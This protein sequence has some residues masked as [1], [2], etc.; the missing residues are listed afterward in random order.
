M[1]KFMSW[2]TDSFSPKINKIAKNPWIASIQDAILA[3]MPMIFIGSFA[4][5]LSIVKDFWK[6]AFCDVPIFFF[7]LKIKSG[8]H[9]PQSLIF[10][11]SLVKFMRNH[12]VPNFHFKFHQKRA[13]ESCFA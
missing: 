9:R 12:R 1:D 11:G 7:C 4:T 13:D 5:I 10:I 8:C 6:G 3:A 2:M